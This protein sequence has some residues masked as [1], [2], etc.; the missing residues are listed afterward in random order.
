VVESAT[1]KSRREPIE[2]KIAALTSGLCKGGNTMLKLTPPK[3]MTF[4]ISFALFLIAAIIHY[5]HVAIPYADN[6]F[7]ILLIGLEQPK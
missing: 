4:L 2:A 5:G 7:T 6:G 3:Q 1:K